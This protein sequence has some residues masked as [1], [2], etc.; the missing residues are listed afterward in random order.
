MDAD[1][2][3]RAWACLSLGLI[4]PPAGEAVGPLL[5]ALQDN[6][7][8]VRTSAG[9]ALGRIGSPAVVA[10]VKALDHLDPRHAVSAAYALGSI[11]TGARRA[12]PNLR[13]ALRDED[14]T[15]SLAAA[16]ALTRIAAALQFAQDTRTVTDLEETLQALEQAKGTRLAAEQ[17]TEWA[18]CVAQTRAALQGLHTVQSAHL[19]DRLVRNR[20]FPWAAGGLLYAS[21][22]LVFWS[23]LLRLRPLLLLQ[24]NDAL[25]RL[26]HLPLPGGGQVSLHTALLVGLFP[27][28][29]RVLD[30]WV[31]QHVEAFRKSYQAKR[32]V[33]ERM[34]YI[35]LPVVVDGEV[36]QQPTARDLEQ[37]F[38]RKRGCLLIWGEGSVGKTTLACQI[39]R[40][41]LA[42]DPSER[43]CEHVMLPVLIEHDLDTKSAEGKA[44]FVALT[45]AVRG[46]LQS[47]D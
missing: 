30:A 15:V 44:P 10:L 14:A 8:S 24:I 1:R 16:V 26:P 4:G 33:H 17:R 35:P 22:L 31:A 11:E 29:R 27:Y 23:I 40:W 28:R 47:S 3:V 43:L 34:R 18:A 7:A 41:A 19:L 39:G 32:T 45:E 42:S 13:A 6:D 25:R 46:Q 37:A 36:V 9:I 2:H 38:G 5:T 21:F 20:W 12:L